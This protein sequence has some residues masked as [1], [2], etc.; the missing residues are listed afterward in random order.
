MRTTTI[1]RDRCSATIDSGFS[2][3]ELKHGDLVKQL[4]Q[5]LDFC[6]TCASEFIDSLKPRLFELETA[7][8]TSGPA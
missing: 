4:D 2:I 6:S 8:A 5:R 3:L 1:N 7:G